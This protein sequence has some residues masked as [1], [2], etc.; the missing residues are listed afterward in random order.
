MTSPL[1]VPEYRRRREEGG[2]RREEG[3][4]EGAGSSRIT[5]ER[6]REQG[7]S[8]EGVE[9]AGDRKQKVV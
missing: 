2:G 3:G 9:G 8:G 6:G 7:S 5:E 4:E 1:L